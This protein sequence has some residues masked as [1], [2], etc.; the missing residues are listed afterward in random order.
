M[1]VPGRLFFGVFGTTF[2][3]R[4]CCFPV[5]ARSPNASTVVSEPRRDC[6]P[7]WI[8]SG[9]VGSAG[10]GAGAGSDFVGGVLLPQPI[11]KQIAHRAASCRV[12]RKFLRVL[13]FWGSS[14][15]G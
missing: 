9:T 12:L 4:N 3:A 14:A 10:F 7:A 15:R 13:R 6:A 5:F 2:A 11:A 1:M 8:S